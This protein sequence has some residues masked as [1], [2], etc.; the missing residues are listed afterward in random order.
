MPV[1]LSVLLF[2]M[3]FLISV[4]DDEGIARPQDRENQRDDES[5]AHTWEV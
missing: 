2:A 1:A 4:D 5:S 3:G